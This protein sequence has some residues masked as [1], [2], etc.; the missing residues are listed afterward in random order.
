MPVAG[1]NWVPGAGEIPFF[2]QAKLGFPGKAP[3]WDTGC[4]K[5]HYSNIEKS[6]NKQFI[7]NTMFIAQVLLRSY[8]VSPP[9]TIKSESN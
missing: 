9:E 7:S 1:A 5:V 6:L 4:R 3:E 2:I 8:P